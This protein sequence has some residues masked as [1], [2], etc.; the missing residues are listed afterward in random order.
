M[1]GKWR[2]KLQQHLYTKIFIVQ[3]VEETERKRG[4]EENNQW[5]RKGCK[6]EAEE[7]EKER[8]W[9]EG[10]ERG[11]EGEKRWGRAGKQE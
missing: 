4:E 2:S 3:K 5:R 1:G 10:T 6:D 11:V 8:R 9:E 7:E